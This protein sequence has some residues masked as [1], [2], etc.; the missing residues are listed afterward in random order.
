[1]PKA[2]AS[3]SDLYDKTITFKHSVSTAE[4]APRRGTPT[5]A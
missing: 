3:Q 5:L 1:M 2:F 4:P